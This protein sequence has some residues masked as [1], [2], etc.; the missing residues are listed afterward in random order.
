MPECLTHSLVLRIVGGLTSGSIYAL[1]ALGYTLVYGV[2][3]LINFAHSEVFMFGT[4]GGLFTLIG[5]SHHGNVAHWWFLLIAAIPAMVFAAAIAF[6]LERFAYR[7]LRRRGAT[8]LSFLISAIGASLFLQSV[9]LVW[10][11]RFYE[12]YPETLAVKQVLTIG[13][14]QISNHDIVV[15]AV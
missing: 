5:L 3:R 10:R 8:R 2:L 13:N 12:T 7:P 1:I 9:M 11:G 6:I 15:F 14:V 4:F